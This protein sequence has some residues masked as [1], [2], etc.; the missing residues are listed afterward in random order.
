M[1]IGVDGNEAN[2]RDKVGVHQYAYEILWSLYKLNN[3]S[4]DKHTFT[5]YLKHTPRKD[6][7]RENLN[8]RYKVLPGK[9][10]WILS[11]LTPHLLFHKNVD[12]LFVPSHYTPVVSR[13]PIVMTVHDLGY[14]DSSEQFKKYDF[15][16]L[17]LWTAKSI[18]ISKALIAISN[19]TKEDIVRH[20]NFATKKIHVVHHGYDKARFNTSVSRN[21]VRRV[22]TKYKLSDNYCLFLS[23]LK[24]SK[25]I[26]GLLTAFS[27][28]KKTSQLSIQLVIAGRRGWFFDPI[29]QL[30]KD[31]NLEQSVIFTGY[32][33]EQD[34]PALYYGSKLFVLPA[35]W[36]GFGMTALES[37]ACGTPV[38]V[39]KVGGL[40][41]VVGDAGLFV[42]P[43]NVEDIARKIS[44]VLSLSSDR[45]E[46]L[47]K[48]SLIQAENFSW[49]KAGKETLKVLE[50]V[51]K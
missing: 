47:V 35:Y 16:Q 11:K 34:K 50:S 36:E 33:D 49:E 23:V 10:L 43:Q 45:Y 38:V 39:S 8:W 46:K 5:I 18:S 19:S 3:S 22:K 15:W 51:I 32:I 14:L 25:N 29:F 9:K 7:P 42:D 48:K 41:E 2:E 12:V 1:N 30:T 17:K 31:L 24:P 20:Y 37:M 4:K 44:Q 27:L 13:I 6:L 40:P 26:E 21:L 28:V